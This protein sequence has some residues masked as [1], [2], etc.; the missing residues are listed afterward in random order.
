[1][2]METR[3]T[4]A[5][6]GVEIVMP[7]EGGPEVLRVERRELPGL[8]PGQVMVRVEAAGVSFAEVQMLKGRYFGQPTFPVVPGYDLV[9][10]VED[11]GEGVDAGMIGRRVAALTETGAWADRVTLDAEELAPVPKGLDS[12]EAVAAITNGV[13]AWQML[14]R[15][16]KVRPGQTVVVHGAS[17]GVG[18][19]LAQ[20]ARLAGAEVIGT[21]SAS[22]HETVRALGAV[23]VDYKG[24]DVPK[25][26]RESSPGG[27]DAIFDHVGGSGLVDSYRMLRRGGTLVSYGSASTLEGTGHRLQPYLPIFGRILLWSTMPNGKRATFYYVKR[28]PKFFG[29][30]LS[31]VLSM[32]AEGKIEARVHRR[33]PLERASEALELLASGKASGKVVLLPEADAR[34]NL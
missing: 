5:T 18:T 15:A 34:P 29:Q 22:K 23:P 8:E 11:V 2:T 17:G 32:L 16:A 30:D 7:H 31:T 26:V 9:G 4:G 27:V 19:P 20:L 3:E 24:E 21:A 13:T 25:R 28:W 6:T 12:A 33:L 10:K 14:H 1:M